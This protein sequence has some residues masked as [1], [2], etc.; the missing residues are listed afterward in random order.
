MATE[1]TSATFI[2]DFGGLSDVYLSVELDSE[3]NGN[4]T[5]FSKGDS[6]HFKVYC[7]VNF[8]VETTSGTVSIGAAVSETIE[9][10]T[11]TFVKGEPASIS[12]YMTGNPNATVWYGDNLGAIT[13]ISPTSV[14]AANKTI[15]S[16]GIA[17]INYPSSYTACTLTPPGSMTDTWHIL[18]YVVAVEA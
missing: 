14:Q 12:K 13:K 6:V 2:I 11:I 16:L 3:L 4:K 7:D 18:V 17:T 9:D 10:E 1:A 5:T 15:D 8:E